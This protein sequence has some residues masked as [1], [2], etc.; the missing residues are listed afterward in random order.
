[1]IRIII[2]FQTNHRDIIFCSCT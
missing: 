2:S 1:M